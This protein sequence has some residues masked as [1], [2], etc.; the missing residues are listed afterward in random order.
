M[1]TVEKERTWND[2]W[3][4]VIRYVLFRDEKLKKQMLV[5]DSVR[6][7][8]FILKYFVKDAAADEL[9]VNEKVRIV[10]YDRTGW[11]TGN[12][13]VKLRYKEFDIYVKED[14]LYNATDDTL[15]SRANLISERQQYLLTKD[16]TIQHLR[17]A[18]EDDFDMWTKTVGYKRY[19]IVFSYKTTV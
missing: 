5:P 12:K 18:Y 15:K 2:N 11:D 13:N 16:D 7:N 9:L 19:H 6:V 17:F 8:E 14:V 10:Y 1:R 3:N 4:N